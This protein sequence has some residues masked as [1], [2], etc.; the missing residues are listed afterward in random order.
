MHPKTIYDFICEIGSGGMSTIYKA[1]SK[2]SDQAIAIKHMKITPEEIR[3]RVMN[4]I[5]IM[6]L[7]MHPNII[8]YQNCFEQH[9]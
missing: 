8:Q 5:G 9:E 3:Q 7:S 6:H 1:V 2:N 4:E